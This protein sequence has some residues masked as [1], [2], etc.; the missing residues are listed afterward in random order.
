M[1]PV[2]HLTLAVGSKIL[3]LLAAFTGYLGRPPMTEGRYLRFRVLHTLAVPL[4]GTVILL[5]WL[6]V[7]RRYKLAF[8]T[9]SAPA[10]G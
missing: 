5:G 8:R 9:E 1:R 2:L 3:V 6:L 4:V 7:V 10:W